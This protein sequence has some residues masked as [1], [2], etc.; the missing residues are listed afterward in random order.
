M[1]MPW[2]CF[3]C[4]SLRHDCGHREQELVEHFIGLDAI[5]DS[6][7]LNA[8]QGYDVRIFGRKK[9][10]ASEQWKREQERKM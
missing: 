3:A 10:H 8:K 4:D 7:R 5:R 2:R 1:N 9:R 6:A